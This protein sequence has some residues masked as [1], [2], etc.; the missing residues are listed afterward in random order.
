MGLVYKP[1][2]FGLSSYDA[3]WLVLCFVSF[4]V[5]K[6]GC[7]YYRIKYVRNLMGSS[8]SFFPSSLPV[9][10]IRASSVCV[11]SCQLA[12]HL[13]VKAFDWLNYET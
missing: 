12:Y 1:Q 6:H 8:I 11:T 5:L 4:S 7:D 2:C 13:C 9:F 3:R 10:D